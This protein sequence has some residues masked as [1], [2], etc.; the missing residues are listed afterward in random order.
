MAG[1]FGVQLFCLSFDA[2]TSHW[3]YALYFQHDCQH[4]PNVL[5]EAM[6]ALQQTQPI[7][8]FGLYKTTQSYGGQG[9]YQAVWCDLVVLCAL[10]W[11][12]RG[13]EVGALTTMGH[14]TR[15][16]SQRPCTLS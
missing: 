1:Y 10:V 8:L 15:V 6:L 13:L 5:T 3:Q 4:N 11:H 2:S 12:R 7:M 14:R 16:S 9:L